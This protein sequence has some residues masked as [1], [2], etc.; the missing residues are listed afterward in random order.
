[1]NH[2]LLCLRAWGIGCWTLVMGINDQLFLFFFFFND[3]FK[4]VIKPNPEF[5]LNWNVNSQNSEFKTA[6]IF[7]TIY[8]ICTDNPT[9]LGKLC[10]K[11]VLTIKGEKRIPPYNNQSI[12]ISTSNGN[13]TWFCYWSVW[14]TW[15]TY[16]WNLGFER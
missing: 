8:G 3:L 10:G 15:L 12:Q 5:W 4:C 2:Q 9:H 7:F 6:L 16:S 1:M 13:N 11:G 14:I